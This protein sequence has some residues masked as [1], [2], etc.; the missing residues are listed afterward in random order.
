[1]KKTTTILI[2][3][4]I[5]FAAVGCSKGGGFKKTKSGLLYKIVGNGNGP[6]AKKGEFLKVNYTQKVRDSVL[7]TSVGAL[8]TYAPV[9]SVGAVYNP[10][11]IFDKLRKGDSAII[12]M[13]ADSLQKKQ[14][15]LPPYIRKNDKLTLSLKVLDILKS[16]TDVKTD[17]LALMETRKQT[18]IKDIEKYLSD[19]NISTEKTQKGVFV[20]I[21]SKGDGPAVD[22]GKAVHVKYKGQTFQGAVFDS[23][24]DSSFGHAEPYVFVIGQRGAIEGWDDGLRLFNKGGKGKLYVPSM[25]AYGP[26]PPPGAPFKAFENLMFDVEIVDV[27]QPK[28]RDTRMPGMQDP[29]LPQR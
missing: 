28:P 17:Q 10:A 8:P 6:T 2:S 9:D 24:L 15:Q 20:E 23:N 27:T 18:E 19:K 11:E 5:L 13:I 3:F 22:S 7:S 1:M 14:G 21:E 16:E 26:N 4:V 25:L 12:V 29:R